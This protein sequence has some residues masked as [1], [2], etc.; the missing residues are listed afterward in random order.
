M[1]EGSD[2][3]EL[4]ITWEGATQARLHLVV[5]NDDLIATDHDALVGVG[6][7]KHQYQAP[8][9]VFHVIEWSLGFEGGAIRNAIA[10]VSINGGPPVTLDAVR[11]EQKHLWL[12]RGAAP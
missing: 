3:L 10:R 8:A 11:S 12:G 5:D 9:S 1:A 7:I 2:K 4:T 6:S